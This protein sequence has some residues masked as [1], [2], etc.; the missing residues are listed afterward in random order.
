MSDGAR[1]SPV[2]VRRRRLCARLLEPYATTL[3]SCSVARSSSSDSSWAGAD[4]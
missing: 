1:S 3:I 2:T 4:T